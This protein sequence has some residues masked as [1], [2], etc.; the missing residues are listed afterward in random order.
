MCDNSCGKKSEVKESDT[1]SLDSY[2]KMCH[3]LMHYVEDLQKEL[4][5]TKLQVE[6]YKMISDQ[7]EKDWMKSKNEFGVKLKEK[8]QE[9]QELKLALNETNKK[10]NGEK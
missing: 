1:T 6:M 2:M 9:I 8:S 10:D 3:D 7:Y 4:R 5:E